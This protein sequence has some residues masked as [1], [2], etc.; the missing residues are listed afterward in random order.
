MQVRLLKPDGQSDITNA[1]SSRLMHMWNNNDGTNVPLMTC[2]SLT[3]ATWEIYFS[4][5][6]SY[7][8][9]CTWWFI[10]NMLR[11]LFGPLN[12]TTGFVSVT[13]GRNLVVGQVGWFPCQKVQPYSSVSMIHPAEQ[14]HSKL[15]SFHWRTTKSCMKQPLAAWNTYC[16]DHRLLQQSN[17]RVILPFP[18]G[19]PLTCLVVT[20]E[21]QQGSGWNKFPALAFL[22][23][24][25]QPQ[26]VPLSQS[27]AIRTRKLVQ[28]I[29]STLKHIGTL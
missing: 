16:C 18:R 1:N 15:G 27:S 23:S 9:M 24:K 17:L 5:F 11:W 19:R 12:P 2:S 6:I 10:S 7:L 20:G 25:I 21:F 26:S 4:L 8:F 14:V 13:Q 22:T 28:R 29:T 3:S